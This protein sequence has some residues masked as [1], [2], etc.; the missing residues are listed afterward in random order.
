LAKVFDQ[1]IFFSPPHIGHPNSKAIIMYLEC[2]YRVD[3][4]VVL[5]FMTCPCGLIDKSM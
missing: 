5:S 1:S 4:I 2:A 3:Y